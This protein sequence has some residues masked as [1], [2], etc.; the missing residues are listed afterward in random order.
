[1]WLGGEE[2]VGSCLPATYAVSG[3]CFEAASSASHLRKHCLSLG[4]DFL[5]PVPGVGS[6]PPESES[7]WVASAR[8][9]GAAPCPPR[10]QD[11]RAV[12]TWDAGGARG[13]DRAVW[14]GTGGHALC[15]T[16]LTGPPT[17]VT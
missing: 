5:A 14:F 4:C 2:A 9:G 1:M 7:S 10:V 17:A 13:P 11:G 8:C 6:S 16:L 12:T 15:A 3:V